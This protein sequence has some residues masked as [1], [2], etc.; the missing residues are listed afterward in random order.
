MN[1]NVSVGAGAGAGPLDPS[2]NPAMTRTSTTGESQNAASVTYHPA[3]SQTPVQTTSTPTD[4]KATDVGKASVKP[5][6]PPMAQSA[7]Q[8]AF[9]GIKELVFKKTP[10]DQK[11]A[12]D[13][14]KSQSATLQQ[15]QLA[16]TTA[17]TKGAWIKYGGA[18]LGAVLMGAGVAVIAGTMGMGAG[19]GILLMA[20][21]AALAFGSWKIGEDKEKNSKETMQMVSQDPAMKV[22]NRFHSMSTHV[23][24]FE[25]AL[26]TILTNHDPINLGDE[27]D[28]KFLEH[29]MNQA[30]KECGVDPELLSTKEEE[31]DLSRSP[32]TETMAPVSHGVGEGV[33]EEVE[34]EQRKILTRDVEAASVSSTP[35]LSEGVTTPSTSTPS[36]ATI[37]S[38]TT[39]VTTATTPPKIGDL[40]ANLQTSSRRNPIQVN[41]P[42]VNYGNQLE[43]AK[44]YKTA[45]DELKYLKEAPDESFLALTTDQYTNPAVALEES[46]TTEKLLSEKNNDTSSETKKQNSLRALILAKKLGKDTINFRE[47]V[48]YLK[49]GEANT[50]L[51]KEFSE[52]KYILEHNNTS[53]EQFINDRQQEIKE[54][55]KKAE[56][57]ASQQKLF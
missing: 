44:A 26:T 9:K 52:I 38:T 8:T 17:K 55:M 20:G 57:Q 47:A 23:E 43:N 7:A 39:P 54:I 11:T 12:I 27:G 34:V 45:Q 41:P 28:R 56:K 40:S 18:A 14:L 4:S 33:T 22:L 32:S 49:S 37:T 2:L 42:I 30:A 24:G 13:T 19:A 15:K 29:A 50:D 5:G 53:P 1:N 10:G 6:A 3:N 31:R 48:I 21:G 51:D 25:K 36:P 16:L 35:T 46:K